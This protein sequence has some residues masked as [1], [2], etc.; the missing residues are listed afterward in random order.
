MPLGG[1][2]EYEREGF[3]GRAV[4]HLRTT[5][6][7]RILS[8]D[9]AAARLLRREASALIDKPLAVLVQMKDRRVFRARLD[10]LPNGGHVDDWHLELTVPGGTSIP[11]IAVVEAGDGQNGDEDELRWSLVLSD[12][13]DLPAADDDEPQGPDRE[14]TLLRHELKQPL[15]AIVS[16]AR[17][18]MLRARSGTL[19]ATD[20]ERVL[21]I[22]VTEALRAAA[23]LDPPPPT[24]GGSS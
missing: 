9:P 5:R 7:S 18:V 1:Q 6:T 3:V 10:L 16:Y 20:L 13:A 8:A 17:G 2:A 11:V 21:E 23:K 15:A 22:I 19:S 4:A 24:S 14:L 12:V